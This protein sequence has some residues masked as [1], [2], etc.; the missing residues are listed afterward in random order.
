MSAQLHQRHQNPL[1]KR[2]IARILSI[3]QHIIPNNR[4]STGYSASSMT[5]LMESLYSGEKMDNNPLSSIQTIQTIQEEEKHSLI[6]NPRRLPRHHITMNSE[7]IHVYGVTH[8][9]ANI[10]LLFGFGYL[11]LALFSLS[12]AAIAAYGGHKLAEY[13]IYGGTLHV[14]EFYVMMFLSTVSVCMSWMQVFPDW[15]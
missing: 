6:S 7:F 1:Q 12:A 4:F 5:G 10:C 3:Q 14:K 8:V 13:H 15:F 9:I 2:A 11:A